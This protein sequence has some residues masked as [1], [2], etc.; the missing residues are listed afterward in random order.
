MKTLSRFLE[1]RFLAFTCAAA[2]LVAISI[3]AFA[4]D[5]VSVGMLLGFGLIWLALCVFNGSGWRRSNDGWHYA[6]AE[7][8][9]QQ[10][11]TQDMTTL[12]SEALADLATWDREK[13][14]EIQQRANTI[15]LLRHQNSRER[16]R[17]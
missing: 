10:Q 8:N 14:G 9:E 6:L 1:I 3:P 11:L 12:L 7:W 2:G 4:G 17:S 15:I 5:E 13:A 16:E